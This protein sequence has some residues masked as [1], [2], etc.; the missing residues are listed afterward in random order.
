MAEKLADE[1]AG[2]IRQVTYVEDGVVH[3]GRFQPNERDILKFNQ[4]TF[5]AG[6]ARDLS[7]AAPQLNIPE[8]HLYL[9]WKKY[10][11]L[12]SPDAGI[13][14]RAWRRFL[15]SAESKPYRVRRRK[16]HSVPKR[17]TDGY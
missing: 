11:E 8:N 16:L 13:K 12:N 14:T 17:A 1:L 3:R 4:E 6:A 10:P 15:N 7:F 2:E 5:D 9:L